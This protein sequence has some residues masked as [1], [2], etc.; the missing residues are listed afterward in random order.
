[1]PEILSKEDI[2][3]IEDNLKVALREDDPVTAILNSI[4]RAGQLARKKKIKDSKVKKGIFAGEIPV[5]TRTFFRDYVREENFPLQQ[6]AIDA[7]FGL[8]PTT[9]D[10]TYEE[11]VLLWGMGSGKDHTVGK[12]LTYAAYWIKHLVDPQQY[13]GLGSGTSIDLANMCINA[14]L[15]KNV[16][17]DDFK[18]TIIRTRIPGTERNWFESQGID[19]RDGKDIKTNEINFGQGITA[20]SLNSETQSD[21]GMNP[22]LVVFDE[23]G[24]FDVARAE[25]LR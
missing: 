23:I 4:G 10:S 18:N 15:A 6:A 2:L 25:E 9:W 17:F 13:F 14:R 5:D 7:V 3:Y 20:H 16:F 21:I 19:I 8:D 12:I 24:G 22:L 1:M 11:F